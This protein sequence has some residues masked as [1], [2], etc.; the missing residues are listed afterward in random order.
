[1]RSLKGYIEEGLSRRDLI[2]Q[3]FA[4]AIVND[5]VRKVDLNVN[6]SE[7]RRAPGLKITPL[8]PRRSAAGSRL[9]KNT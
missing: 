3:G 6:T 9:F 8:A 2:E 7:S 1:M 5:V 4:E